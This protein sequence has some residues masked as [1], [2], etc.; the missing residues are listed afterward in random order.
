MLYVKMLK[1]TEE[2]IGF[3]HMFIIGG[4]SIGGG[5]RPPL[6]T[7]M[8]AAP[9]SQWRKDCLVTNILVN[10]LLIF[11]YSLTESILKICFF[12]FIIVLV[13]VALRLAAKLTYTP[14]QGTAE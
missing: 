1:E 2:T 7:S 4:I 14:M 5:S 8:L 9:D 10:L 6:V 12:C 3:S 13:L 11:S